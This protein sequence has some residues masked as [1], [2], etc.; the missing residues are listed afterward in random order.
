MD[1]PKLKIKHYNAQ[2]V[3]NPNPSGDVPWHVFHTVRNAVV[4]C[5]RK[6][7][8]VGALGVL[9]FSPKRPRFDILS[10]ERG[11]PSPWYYIVD[12]Q[13]DHERYLYGEL[14]CENPFTLAWLSDIT[15]TLSEFRGWGLCICNM[16]DCYL[17]IFESKLMVT[18]PV[19]ENCKT[20]NCFASVESGKTLRSG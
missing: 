13:Y 8:P 6:H 2:R 18:G 14:F 4:R 10:W 16:W 19:F 5:C 15:D 12:D 7:G 3:P 17:I 9:P 1:L 20:A 11:D